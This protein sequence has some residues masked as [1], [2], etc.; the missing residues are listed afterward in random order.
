MIYLYRRKTVIFL[1]K[2]N[3][4][5]DNKKIMKQYDYEKNNDI[6]LEKLT[7]GTHKKVCGFVQKG[8][9]MNKKFVQK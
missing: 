6:D 1:G 9:L 7:I 5:K 4:L 3:Y 2:S 8:I